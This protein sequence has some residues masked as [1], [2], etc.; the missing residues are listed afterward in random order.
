MAGNK[1][2]ASQ[3]RGGG[4]KP[5]AVQ[6]IGPLASQLEDPSTV[7]PRVPVKSLPL[8]ERQ[9]IALEMIERRLAEKQQTNLKA[10]NMVLGAMRVVLSHEI[11]GEKKRRAEIVKRNGEI[12][13]RWEAMAKSADGPPPNDKLEDHLLDVPPEIGLN[14]RVLEAIDSALQP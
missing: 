11:E 2:D 13:E 8:E 14:A 3:V 1:F 12:T 9:V 5:A 7:P 4:H 6:K 10:L